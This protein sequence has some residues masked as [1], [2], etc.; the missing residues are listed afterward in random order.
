[1]KLSR[2]CWVNLKLTRCRVRL[3]SVLTDS[4][5]SQCTKS[6]QVAKCRS[7]V[8]L[9]SN[10]SW[11]P[12]IESSPCLRGEPCDRGD[13]KALSSGCRRGRRFPERLPEY[14]HFPENS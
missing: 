8:H 9:A 3:G 14:R 13:H 2:F 7:R 11:K 4:K 1:M 12:S 6:T 5:L 10:L